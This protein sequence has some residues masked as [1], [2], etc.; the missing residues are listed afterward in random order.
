VRVVIADDVLL[1]RSGLAA[2][3]AQGGVETVAEA[4]T[5]PEVIAAV[6]T[7]RPDAAVVDVRM[8]PTFTDEGIVAARMV[9]R[10][11]PS[12]GVVVLSQSLESS[13]AMRL[14]E[15]FPSGVGYLLKDR[16]AEVATLVDTLRR[17]V[18]GECVVDPSVV[19]RLLSRA[20]RRGPLDRLTD[21]E[22]DVLALMAEGRSNAGIAGQLRLS[23]R[24]VETHV[25]R[26]FAKLGLVE[27][28]VSGNRRVLAV[29]AHLRQ[30]NH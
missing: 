3:L 22:R 2:M 30:G 10:D 11:H 23:E 4:T 25:S 6:A 9:R 24:T 1:V 17:V 13:Y 26:I 16:I 27:E 7:H 29:L 14:L 18:A 21:R 28:P 15:E 12:V 19:T 8:P 20:R 5:G